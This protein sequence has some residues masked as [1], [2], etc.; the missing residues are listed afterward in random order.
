MNNMAIITCI[1]V[2]SQSATM[3]G[4]QGGTEFTIG[5]SKESSARKYAAIQDLLTKDT[6]PFI[7]SPEDEW[8][9][10]TP[11]DIIVSEFEK[12]RPTITDDTPF[13]YVFWE[14]TDT[15]KWNLVDKFNNVT[16]ASNLVEALLTCAGLHVLHEDQTSS[17]LDHVSAMYELLKELSLHYQAGNLQ[18]GELQRFL[19]KNSSSILFASYG[20]RFGIAVRKVTNVDADDKKVP[21][22]RP[23]EFS[24]FN[25]H[26]NSF[27]MKPLFV[28]DRSADEGIH[29]HL[30]TDID[31]CTALVP[32]SDFIGIDSD[33]VKSSAVLFTDY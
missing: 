3:V 24:I 22:L 17:A 14:H 15:G 2:N 27:R 7:L 8:I 33:V 20:G 26:E 29:S 12:N 4:K 10:Q 21:N 23:P 31:V 25:R 9:L 28:T 1:L 5:A 30:S 13:E 6:P 16:D 11:R 19:L 18:F 32:L